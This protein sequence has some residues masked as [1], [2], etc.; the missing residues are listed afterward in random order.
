[1]FYNAIVMHGNL[2]SSQGMYV[3]LKTHSNTQTLKQWDKLEL[4][5]FGFNPGYRQKTENQSVTTEHLSME[6]I[7]HG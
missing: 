7:T 1:M 4:S 3:P 5:S 2:W 6:I